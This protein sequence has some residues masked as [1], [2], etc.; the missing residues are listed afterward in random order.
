[1]GSRNYL[2]HLYLS[3]RYI[4]YFSLLLYKLEVKH[5]QKKFEY[6][7]QINIYI[8]RY[9]NGKKVSGKDIEGLEELMT[10]C[11]MCNDSSVDYNDVSCLYIMSAC[12]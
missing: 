8:F 10:I 9:L 4:S 2:I 11:S 6:A 12:S 7:V 3:V 5:T 1:M